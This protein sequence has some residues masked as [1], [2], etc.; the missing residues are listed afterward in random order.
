M[1][2]RFLPATTRPRRGPHRRRL[3]LVFASLLAV[4]SLAGFAATG[5]SAAPPTVTTEAATTVGKASATLNGTVN[6][7]G[8]FTNYYFEYGTTVAY[9]SKTSALNI[10]SGSSVVKV[11]KFIFGLSENVKYHFRVVATSADGTS[12]GADKTFEYIPTWALQTT[13]S[14]SGSSVAQLKDVSCL[15]GGEC[16]AVGGY[17]TGGIPPRAMG[18]RW[19]GTAWSLNTMSM[20][21]SSGDLQGISCVSS[22]ACTAVGWYT[23][24]SKQ[25]LVARWNGTAWSKQEAPGDITS[26]FHGVSCVSAT[27]CIA[28]GQRNGPPGSTLAERWNGTEWQILTTPNP[29]SGG[30][31]NVL[32]DVSCTS[33]TFCMAVG[34]SVEG[35]M[36]FVWNG[37][38]WT[39]Q[40]VFSAG[41]AEGVSCTASNACT[42]VGWLPGPG[43]IGNPV[44]LAARWNGTAW[45]VQATSVPAEAK[46]TKLEDVSCS[47]PTVCV[48][49]GWS[50][51]SSGVTTTLAERWN[52]T[53]WEIQSSPNPAGATRSALLG[54]SCI[55]TG[56]CESVGSSKV[57]TKTLTLGE[58]AS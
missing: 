36:T 9:G 52:G 28:V 48:G 33:S 37:S 12:F 31:G 1:D 14:P 58:R 3:S 19:N 56:A 10:G 49:T 16:F 47:S 50:E 4:S 11:S 7:N 25:V 53:S 15:S 29:T 35:M 41:Q 54:V 8:V 39:N 5:A 51:G 17:E 20:L 18:E 13:P 43:G 38:F 24:P 44:P 26:E 46:K 2:M 22:S 6:P 32:Q 40:K 45:S 42:L 23:T 57:E 34:F 27:E 21:P 30:A 55:S